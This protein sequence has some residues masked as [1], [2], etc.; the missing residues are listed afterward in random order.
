MMLNKDSPVIKFNVRAEDWEFQKENARKVAICIH[1]RKDEE[2]RLRFDII[3][4]YDYDD[5]LKIR[6]SLD[7]IFGPNGYCALGG[8][9]LGF[10]FPLQA[11]YDT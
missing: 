8:Y 9:E 7:N 5:F 11:Y 10:L 2:N 6:S 3:A 1:Y 4:E